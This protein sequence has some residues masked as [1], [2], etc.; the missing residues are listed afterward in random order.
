M[1]TCNVIVQP[2]S[3]VCGYPVSPQ[4]LLETAFSSLCSLDIHFEHH[5]TLCERVYLWALSWIPLV[6]IC[7]FMPVVNHNDYQL[8]CFSNIIPSIPWT[9][10]VFPFICWLFGPFFFFFFLAMFGSFLSLSPPWLRI[11]LSILNFLRLSYD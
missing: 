10:A 11:F 8:L 9:W 2:F 5:L 1:Y 4:H 6:Y 3:F 7:I